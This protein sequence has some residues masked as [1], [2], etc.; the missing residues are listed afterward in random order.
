MRKLLLI[1]VAIPLMGALGWWYFHER[2]LTDLGPSYREYAYV[3]NGK[4]NTV[5]VIDLR[6]FQPAK[7]IR[8]G[9]EPTGV[10]VNPRRNEVYVVNSGS[11]SLNVIDA[12]SNAVTATIT[13]QSK[14]FFISV[15]DDGKRGYVANSASNT[16]SVIDLDRHAVNQNIRVGAAP[17]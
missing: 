17:G 15:S 12:E 1:I 3:T 5:T 13:T 11:G 7:T 4:S 14:P 9:T 2:Q 8:V 16:V 6:T 10:A